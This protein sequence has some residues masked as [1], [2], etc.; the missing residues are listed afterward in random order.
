MPREPRAFSVEQLQSMLPKVGDRLMKP[1]AR[2]ST[3]STE[4][5]AP[6]PCIVVEVNKE[7]LWYRVCFD[8]TG[9]HQCFKLPEM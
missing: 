2:S 9:L 8:K 6:E 7:Y 3:F 4:V 5:I 1:M